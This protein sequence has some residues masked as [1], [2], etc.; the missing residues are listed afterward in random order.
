[1]VK[2]LKYFVFLFAIA[3]LLITGFSFFYSN[4]VVYANHETPQCNDGIDNDADGKIDYPE[5]GGCGGANDVNEASTGPGEVCKWLT[6]NNL[7]T[8]MGVSVNP[9]VA[10]QTV[11]ISANGFLSASG[12]PNASGCPACSGTEVYYTTHASINSAKVLSVVSGPDVSAAQAIFVNKQFS[13]SVTPG[14]QGVSC[15]PVTSGSQ[16]AHTGKNGSYSSSRSFNV[17]T[18]DE[19]VYILEVEIIDSLGKR[20]SD[21]TVSF[22]VDHPEVEEHNLT[23]GFTGTCPNMSSAY[24]GLSPKSNNN[25]SAYSPGGALA[26]YNEDTDVTLTAGTPPS[27]CTFTTFKNNAGN[28]RTSPF[29]LTMDGDKPNV[30]AQFDQISTYDLT[31]NFMGSCSGAGG[32]VSFNPTPNSGGSS[33]SGDCTRPFNDGVDVDLTATA[34][35]GCYFDHWVNNASQSYGGNPYLD[36]T[37]DQDRTFEVWFNANASPTVGTVSVNSNIATTWTM[38]GPPGESADN[39]SP[40]TS[41]TFSNQ[42]TG[43]YTISPASLAGYTGPTVATNGTQSLNSGQT[44]TFTLTYTEDT[45]NPPGPP[46][47]EPPPQCDDDEDNDG[48]L[49]VDLEDSDCS[50]PT[51]TTEG[52]GGGEG[53][54]LSCSPSSQEVYVSQVANLSASGGSG[55]TWSA[56]NGTPSSGS[57]STF[58]VLYGATGNNTVTVTGG[59]TDQ[60]TVSVIEASCG[61][62]SCEGAGGETCSTCPTDCG[63]CALPECNDTDDNDDDG[64]TDYPEDPE[65]KSLEDNSE[66]NAP[67]FEEF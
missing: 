34:N 14:T 46:P 49:L 66:E 24:V 17:S 42:P 61:N 7:P 37:M 10:D 20:L 23:I 3:T 19:G 45:E 41:R 35:S 8:T 31:I 51:D 25:I 43:T 67:T 22:T 63:A 56:P 1:M 60:C 38:S 5:D 29:T 40:S 16:V 4:D 52:S 28:N 50:G 27:G 18:L 39:Y 64:F 57:G 9:F 32:T 30:K 36:R 6:N 11:T 48:D 65:C 2:F 53:G 55:Y 44:I 59:G 12:N 13:V 21:N 15:Q 26:S 58:D 33:C 54:G 47:P 62:A